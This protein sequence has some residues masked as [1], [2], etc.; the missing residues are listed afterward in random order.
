MN[1]REKNDIIQFQTLRICCGGFR[2]SP[3]ASLQV[4]MPLEYRRMLLRMVYWFS[5][6]GHSEMHPVKKVLE[7]CWE[8]EY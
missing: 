2:T 8:Y 5:V 4:E 7:K 6:K 1:L 3:V